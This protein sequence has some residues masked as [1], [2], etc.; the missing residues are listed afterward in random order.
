MTTNG[1]SSSNGSAA[2]WDAVNASRSSCSKRDGAASGAAELDSAEARCAEAILR[3]MAA[4]NMQHGVSNLLETRV[5]EELTGTEQLRNKHIFLQ[6][7]W[8]VECLLSNVPVRNPPKSGTQ[9]DRHKNRVKI[10]RAPDD[11]TH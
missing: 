7:S 9:I 4:T 8:L 3:R 2:S 5:L 10:S 11:I 1:S 6:V